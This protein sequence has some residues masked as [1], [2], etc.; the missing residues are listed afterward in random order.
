MSGYIAG[1]GT[2]APSHSGGGGG[3]F[4]GFVGNL[5]H[6]VGDSARGFFP[7][8]VHLA[9]HPIGS[10]EGMGKA[11]WQTWS[12]LFH[13]HLHEFGNNFYQHPLAPMLDVLTV[14][15]GGASL[16]AKVGVKASDLGLISED[17]SLARLG[18]M[19]K[20]MEIKPNAEA[21]AKA[22]DVGR[23]A[24]SYD[25]LLPKNPI[26]NKAYRSWMSFA[27]KHPAVPNWFGPS[28]VYD[29]LEH[30]DW[31]NS[32]LALTATLS[33]AMKAG[34][35]FAKAGHQDWFHLER[36]I[37]QSSYQ[38]LL[39]NSP[40]ITVH[41]IMTKYHGE[42]PHGFAP[43]KPVMRFDKPLFHR[44]KSLNDFAGHIQ[45]FGEKFLGN[46]KEWQKYVYKDANGQDVVSAAHRRA[47]NLGTKDG[48]KS[49]HFL[50]Q[51][52]RYPTAIWKYA[53]VGASPRTLVDNTVG[54]WLMYSMR[55]SGAHGFHGFVQAV[56]YVRGERKALQVL[57]ETGKLPED[58]SYFRHFKGELGNTYATAMASP[59][60]QE[61]TGST[62]SKLY[63]R[64]VYGAVHNWADRPARAAAISAY[65]R[66]DKL[67][68]SLMKTGKPFEDAA[69]T[70][71]AS[72]PALRDRAI[73]HARSV[74][75]NYVT[76]SRTE[77][78]LRDIVPFY[79]WD[80]HIVMHAA[81]M[82]R[83][84]PAVVAAG[85]ALGQQGANE[86]RKMLGDIPGFMLGE[87]PL[88]F[89]VPGEGGRKTLLDTTGLNPYSTVPDLA[90]LAQA[91]TLGHTEDKASNTV[92]G[93][94]NPLI[95]SLVQQTMGTSS[96]G[97]PIPTHG[98]I[99][100]SALTDIFNSVRPV[101]LVRTLMGAGEPD[102]TK[103]GTPRLYKTDINTILSALSGFPIKE[104]DLSHAVELQKQIENGGK[105]PKKGSKYVAGT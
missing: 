23:V 57:K 2:V 91:V 33:A 77:R 72:N 82:L 10:L 65:L 59:V 48:A 22:K 80:K 42:M 105:K 19:P 85:T 44:P 13:G 31:G 3:G 46:E 96:T 49:A 102:T 14:F 95:Q 8:L 87:I 52:Y 70:A 93:T 4:T 98:G 47:Y 88:P 27:E 56:K 73:A 63:K 90:S 92:L 16:A 67:V 103:S 21:A 24:R 26:Y 64:S 89:S 74:A 45:R 28:K 15:T 18:H 5:V 69:D 94:V 50:Y 68:R 35:V 37:A 75:G 66:G 86:T 100:P 61:A 101:Q 58:T 41:D 78:I 12:P 25:K 62:M 79:L 104:A 38:D 7:G 99:V 54:N 39:A 76:L 9:E 43:V 20:S 34:E 11:T 29:R 36:H 17:S 40:K 53:Q 71:L 51:L 1:P 97:A 30:A 6:D 84:R 81:S 83:D 55:Q 60:G 32:H